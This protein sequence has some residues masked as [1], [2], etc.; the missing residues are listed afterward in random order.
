MHD[1]GEVR[2]CAVCGL[3][4][5]R[6]ATLL[7]HEVVSLLEKANLKPGREIVRGLISPHAGYQY[8]G[9]TAA[10]GFSLLRGRKYSSV[11]IVSPS[12]REYFN[13]VTVFRGD[14][15]ATPLGEVSVNDL[16]RTELL[17]ECP[18]VEASI[19]GHREEHAIEVQLPFLQEVLKDFT[20]LPVV[21]GNQCREN[22]FELGKALARIT[23][24]EDILL[25]ASTDLSHYHSSDVAE[26]LD[27][28]MIEDVRAFDGE[29]LMK[30]LDSGKTEA[31]GG[32]PTVAVMMALRKM[33]IATM[34]I[35]H[36]CNSGD[37]TGQR[38]QVVGYLSAAA[39]A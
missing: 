9:F 24:N 20:I 12:H 35:L 15:Y 25:L 16:L 37:V 19:A 2:K 5:S 28:V 32:G 8:S 38:E 34:Q 22:C 39:V 29:R 21:I 23:N 6:E 17:R 14:A 26:E 11:V 33:G 18:V 27:Q 3:F 36:H 13:G 10:H 31:C 30:D 1:P 7:H 4:Y